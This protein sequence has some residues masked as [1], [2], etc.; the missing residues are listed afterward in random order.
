MDLPSTIVETAKQTKSR[1]TTLIAMIS[2]MNNGKTSYIYMLKIKD[3]SNHFFRFV[4]VCAV[5]AE[6]IDNANDQ[7][8]VHF[9]ILSEIV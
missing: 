8:S 7:Q 6:H 4:I 5:R 1:T 9:D 2:L 3:A